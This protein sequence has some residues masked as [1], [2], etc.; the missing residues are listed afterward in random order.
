MKRREAR[1]QEFQNKMADNVLSKMDAKQKFEDDM[2]QRYEHEREMRH[3]QM[4]ERRMQRG[5]AE[6]EKMRTFL[7][8]QVNEKVNREKND[9]EN[10]DQQARMWELDK[11][12]YEEE[13]KRLKERIN[14]INKDNSQY[15]MN[16]MAAKHRAS[17]KMNNMEMAIN[18][19]LLREVN[20]K[21]KA[22]SNYEGNGSLKSG[23]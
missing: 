23:Q 11:K 21:L 5:K 10:I 12:N 18:K 14:K 17:A 16:Q 7:S 9:K 6:Q 2:L 19:P 22:F 13:E 3:R 8:Q 1:A 15:L 4:E 20:Q